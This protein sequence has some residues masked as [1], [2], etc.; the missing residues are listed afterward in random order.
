M[1]TPEDDCPIVSIGAI[2]HALASIR[3][4]VFVAD[5]QRK[6]AFFAGGLDHPARH[7]SLSLSL[8]ATSRALGAAT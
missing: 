4:V 5:R 2:F 6:N 3:L 8:Q 7:G 1:E